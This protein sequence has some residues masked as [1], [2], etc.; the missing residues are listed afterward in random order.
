MNYTACNRSQILDGIVHRALHDAV[1]KHGFRRDET[2]FALLHHAALL[3]GA[4]YDPERPLVADAMEDMA[5]RLRFSEHFSASR[6]C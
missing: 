4:A 5:K 1:M 6:T 3:A 2:A